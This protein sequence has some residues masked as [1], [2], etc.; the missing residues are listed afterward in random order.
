MPAHVQQ[1][2]GAIVVQEAPRRLSVSADV[3]VIVLGGGV[4][5]MAAALAAA[6]GGSSV[7]LIERGNCLGGTATAGMMA[8]FYTPYRCAHGIP[9]RIFDRLIAAGGAFPGEII[10]FDHEVFK[11]VAF[12][13]VA[14]AGVEILLHTICADVIMDGD[15]VR[16]L[17]IENKGARTAVLGRVL[18]DASGDADIA[19]RA[20]APVTKGRETDSK[21]RPMTLLFRMGGVDVDAVLDYVRTQPEEFSK[22]PNQLVLD[23]AGGNIR[24]FGFFGLVEQAKRAGL[25]YPDCHYFRIESVRPDRGT[26]LV[27]TVRVYNVDGTNP[28][29]VTR[30]EIEGRRQQRL[31]VEFARACL[32]GFSNAYVLDSASHIGVRETRRI[33]GEY[34][35]TE[36]DIVQQAEFPDTIGIDANRQNP[37]GARHSPDGMEGST[38][39]AETREQ[40]A[41]LFVY[42][43]PYRCLLPQKVEGLL[44]AGRIVSANHEADGYTRNQPACMVTGQAAG[45]AAALALRCQTTPRALNVMLLQDRLRRLGAKLHPAELG[46]RNG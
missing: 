37:K 14:E 1:Q 8:L 2:D 24:I 33:V 45:A 35:L 10:S 20:G 42:E 32:P 4:A 31:L 21:M 6:E 12:E 39:D 40:V 44:V 30:A 3:D 41:S 7:L 34:V 5:G 29:D 19:A 46:N 15:R 17:V 36:E 22:D 38:A 18:I 28:R 23:V 16:G 13:M 27:N 26:V 43:I 25:L 11:S 9:K